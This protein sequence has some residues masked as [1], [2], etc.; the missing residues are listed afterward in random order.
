MAYQFTTSLPTQITWMLNNL[1]KMFHSYAYALLV[2]GFKPF[3]K[4]DRQI[5]SFPQFSGW[6]KPYLKP[7][8]SLCSFVCDIFFSTFSCSTPGPQHPPTVHPSTRWRHLCLDIGTFGHLPAIHENAQGSLGIHH[9]TW[10]QR[11]F[12]G[13]KWWCLDVPRS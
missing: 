12:L 9:S 10:S 6:N 4:Y 2:G 11:R 3:K 8:A 7:P 5:G 13:K 1:K